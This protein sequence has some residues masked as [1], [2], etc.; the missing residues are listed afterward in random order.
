MNHGSFH[1]DNTKHESKMHT[2]PHCQR[3][4]RGNGIYYH[5][6]ICERRGK[7]RARACATRTAS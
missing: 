3:V 4:I 1:L 6:R 5:V 7:R 2:C